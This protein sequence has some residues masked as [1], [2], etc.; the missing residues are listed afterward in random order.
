LFSY[1]NYEKQVSAHKGW[2]G[3]IASSGMNQ[4][5]TS[6]PQMQPTPYAR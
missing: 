6:L 2:D 1:E 3:H 4:E 5:L